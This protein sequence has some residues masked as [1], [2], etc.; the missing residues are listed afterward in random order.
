MK[1]QQILIGAGIVAIILLSLFLYSFF[2]TPEAS[3]G[4]I[5][6]A[7]V[8]VESVDTTVDSES[9]GTLLTID[10]TQATASFV[11]DEILR[12]DDFTVVGTTDQVGG[13]VSFDP[14]NP[15]TAQIGEIIINARTFTTDNELRNR[16]IQNRILF[17]DEYEFIQFQPT[18][19]IG[20]PESITV[21]DSVDVEI[22]GELTILEVTQSETFV[23]TLSYV[24]SDE[25]SGS[26][27]T[28]II[29]GD[30]GV[31][32]PLTPSVSFVA[33]ELTLTLEF[34]AIVSE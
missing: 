4:D 24:N 34:V 16:A 31:V 2:Q 11:I 6:E 25:I 27:L 22:V 12:G 15:A 18:T 13:Q 30:Y 17:T 9:S 20:L 10:A 8:A 32:V 7:V 3:S 5:A 33:D 1:K 19:I 29:Y 14:N 23:A 28:T 21:G 26:A